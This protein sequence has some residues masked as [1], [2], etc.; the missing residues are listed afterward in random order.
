MR[1]RIVSFRAL[2]ITLGLAAFVGL[3]SGSAQAVSISIGDI[4]AE[5]GEQ[6]L[7]DVV[8]DSEG[9]SVA[10]VQNDIVF[11]PSVISAAAASA[12]VINPE[13]GDRL[14]A[15]D[16]DPQ[17]APCK[18]LQR[19]LADCPDAAGCPEGSDGLARFRGIIIS[20]ANVNVIPDGVLY[21]CTFQVSELAQPGETYTLENLNGGAS[22][23]AGAALGT[24]TV[25]G[26]ITI[27][28]EVVPTPTPTLAPGQVRVNVGSVTAQAGSTVMVPVTLETNGQ[29]VAG[30]QNDIIFDPSVISA[31][32]ASVC[33]I[34]PEI[35]DRLDAC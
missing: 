12:C 35:G 22:D 18:S 32:A 29:S 27:G 31:S 25:S 20:L 16:E 30:V 11:D 4:T 1:N 28:G 6:I 19:N 34:N 26:T 15:C 24:T 8:L 10:G 21:T 13:I 17:T 14:D 5:P 9:E 33:V 23:P 2:G 7:V 3:T